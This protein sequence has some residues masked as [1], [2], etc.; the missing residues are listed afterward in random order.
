[1]KYKPIDITIGA[2]L[3]AL[4]ERMG[5][6]TRYVADLI[7]KSNVA[8]TY[9]ETGRNGVDLSTLK[10]LCNIYNVDMIEFLEEIY[11]QI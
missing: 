3:K 6:S 9:F 11:D 2:R 10:K 1:M 8:V 7:G 4:R 5:Y